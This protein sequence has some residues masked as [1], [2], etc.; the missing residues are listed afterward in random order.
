[1]PTLLTDD[2]VVAHLDA[3]TSLAA[4]RDAVVA[5]YEGRLVAPPR[6]AAPLVGG[7]LVFTAGQLTDQWYGFA[8]YD[9]F[10]HPEAEQTVV[11]HEAETGRVRAVAV[12]RELGARRTGGIG[13]VAV[14]ALARPEAGTVGLIGAGGQAWAQL[15]ATAAVRPLREVTVYCRTHASREAF[16]ARVRAELKVPAR[17]V[18]SAAAAVRDRDL[19]IL[20]TSS[21]TPVID[22]A[23]LAPGTHVN[24]IGFKQQGRS[25]FGLDLVARAAVIASDSPAQA[26][27]YD[28][29]LITGGEPMRHLGAIVAGAAP[30]RVSAEEITLF[31]SVGL[32]GAEAFLLDRLAR[33]VALPV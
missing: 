6:T 18:A 12:G 28:P 3:A 7:R 9:T 24:A 32:A 10:G 19:V 1:M 33:R 11:L 17:A 30:G 15:W 25:E 26:A 20:A 14:D 5:A 2:D 23:D 21:R 31:C 4:M 27:S 16:A 13:A 22:A 29:P 8:S